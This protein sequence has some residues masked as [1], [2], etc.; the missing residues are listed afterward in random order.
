M[1]DK[2]VMFEENMPDQNAEPV[3]QCQRLRW[4]AARPNTGFGGFSWGCACCFRMITSSAWHDFQKKAA[5]AHRIKYVKLQIARMACETKPALKSCLASL[6]S[7]KAD[8]RPKK[9]SRV[10]KKL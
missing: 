5:P 1:N 2:I 9:L 8:L 6:E 10:R 4:L 3:A 7:I